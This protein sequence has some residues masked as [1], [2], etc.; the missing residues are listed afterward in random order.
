MR[1]TIT[2]GVVGGILG[3][4]GM[5]ITNMI[6]SYLGIV[7][8]TSL[9]I[10][11][12]LFLNWEQANTTF[13]ILIGLINHLFIGAI[14]GVIIAFVLKYFGKDYYL[15]KGLGIT[16]LGY[17]IGMGFIIP[18]IGAVPQMRND[19]LTLTGHIF[20]YTVFGLI[21]S[22]FIAKYAK[23]RVIKNITLKRR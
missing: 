1:D 22:Y 18:L 12:T 17:L 2:V 21:A 16:G 3:T 4:I 10:T 6:L 5:H 23:F 14:I 13:G 7:K 9:Q 15:L 19:T 8:I 20:S 11:A